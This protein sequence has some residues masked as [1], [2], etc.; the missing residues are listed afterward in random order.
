MQKELVET[1]LA[2]YSRE[3]ELEKERTISHELRMQLKTAMDAV[4]ELQQQQTKNQ[5]NSVQLQVKCD[6]IAKQYDS[7]M[8]QVTSAKMHE[9]E[10]KIKIQ[11][12][13]ENLHYKDLIN[14]KLK[15]TLKELEH[16]NLRATTTV[17]R[18]I[19]KLKEEHQHLQ[20]SC[21]AVIH[22]NRR[23]QTVGLCAYA[24]HQKD[25]A[26]IKDLLCMLASMSVKNI[27][28]VEKFINCDIHPE[29]KKL[30]SQST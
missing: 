22:F 21:E 9:M 1:R 18:K 14:K 25:K 15:Q 12:L 20:K 17:D 6:T 24:I 8:N 26:K 29:I 28:F 16:N 10:C 11:S 3:L 7:M 5:I 19:V 30:L 13:E 27:E 23:L 2:L 4:N